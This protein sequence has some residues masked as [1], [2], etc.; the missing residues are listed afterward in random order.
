MTQSLTL[1][2][3][4]SDLKSKAMSLAASY[5]EQ[6][7]S[8]SEALEM[9]WQEAKGEADYEDNPYPFGEPD[10]DEDEELELFEPKPRRRA[11]ANPVET[12]NLGMYVL[13]AGGGY[14]LWCWYASR[15]KSWSW[16]PWKTSITS[17][18]ALPRH[19]VSP[20]AFS[21]SSIVPVSPAHGQYNE[22]EAINLIVP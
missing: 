4:G 19:T 3:Y 17:Y 9:G 6:G 16:T 7:Y 21:H 15:G 8:P 18:R 1:Q 22:Y 5:R 20:S 12:S 10:K 13:L 14:L 2:H 11:K